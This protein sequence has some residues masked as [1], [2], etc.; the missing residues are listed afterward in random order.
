MKNLQ[1][2]HTLLLQPLSKAV[3]DTSCSHC[4]QE[5]LDHTCDR[6]NHFDYITGK[7][8]QLLPLHFLLTTTLS[9]QGLVVPPAMHCSTAHSAHPKMIIL[10]FCQL[11]L[12]NNNSWLLLILEFRSTNIANLASARADPVTRQFNLGGLNSFPSGVRAGCC[13][14]TS[15]SVL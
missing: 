4:V 1:Q 13:F 8:P 7:T 5:S 12:Q 9:P 3:V 11:Q 14:I 2:T 6:V 15:S 10:G